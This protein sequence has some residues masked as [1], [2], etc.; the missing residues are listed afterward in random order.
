MSDTNN[1]QEIAKLREDANLLL[2]KSEEVAAIATPEQEAR[3]TE[4]L[5][6][7]KRRYKLVDEKRKEYVKPLKDVIDKINADFK[8]ILDPLQQ[9]EV[10]VKRGMTDYRDSEEFKE[11][12]KARVMAELQAKQAA[13]A[14]KNDMTPENLQRA[15]EAGKELAEARTEAPKAVG[16]QSGTAAFRKEWKF[17]IVDGSKLPD[18]VNEAVLKLAFEKGLYDQVIRGMIKSGHRD[19]PGVEMWEE[20]T[21]IIR[22]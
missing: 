14:L 6:Q 3:A 9:V 10:I 16:T 17:K 15:Q 5:A 20:S 21:P 12:E 4:Y 2:F 7:V 18:R 11:K 8:T 19:I 13:N 22:S 1:E